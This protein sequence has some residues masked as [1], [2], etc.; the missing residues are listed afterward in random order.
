MITKND[1]V[2]LLTDLEEKGINVKR[3]LS[4]LLT[5]PSLSLEVLKFINSHKQLDLVN[6][7][8]RLRVNYNKK[9]S[10]LYIN[11][12]KEIDDPEEVLTTLSAMLTQILLYSKQVDNKQLF[13]SHARADEISKVLNT[14]FKTYDITNALKLLR[15]IKADLK[16]VMYIN[17]HEDIDGN[18][19]IKK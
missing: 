11:I 16:C 18:K 7:Y 1:C 15:L 4:T 14:Y 5:A 8:D 19:I 2:L 13:L 12:V 10:N 6:F 3:H 17:G 9:K